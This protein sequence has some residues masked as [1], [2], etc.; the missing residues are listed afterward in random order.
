MEDSAHLHE[1]PL[2]PDD[3]QVIPARLLCSVS[4]KVSETRLQPEMPC[5]V[6]FPS[7]GAVFSCLLIS[8]PAALFF[9]LLRWEAWTHSCSLSP[10]AG[11]WLTSDSWAS[12]Y[13]PWLR[14]P[15]AMQSDLYMW[16]EHEFSTAPICCGFLYTDFLSSLWPQTCLIRCILTIFSTLFS[17][18][19]L[20]LPSAQG[21]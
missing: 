21:W 11:P 5:L 19:V 18:L 16:S 15:W 1:Y 13:S 2:Y 6:S 8:G 3:D 14:C 20:W 9:Q 17:R 7:H 12:S 10:P 4:E